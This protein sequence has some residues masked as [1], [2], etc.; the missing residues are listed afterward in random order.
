MGYKVLVTDKI[1]KIAVKILQDICEV[2]YK[3]VLTADDLKAIIQYYDAL[4]IRSSSNV[5]KD[6]IS[7]SD[8]LKVIGRAG[9]G[10]DNIDIEA[11]TEQGIVV[12]NSP[13][14]EYC[15]GGRTYYSLDA[16][17]DQ[18]YTRR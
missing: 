1:D 12:I 10:V 11:A 3:P 2:D 14:G 4:M 6:I 5:T 15:R 17:Y 9:V 8:R 7:V 13:E 16:V 18:T